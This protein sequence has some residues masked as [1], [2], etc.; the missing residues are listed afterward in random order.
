MQNV[1]KLSAESVAKSARQAN[2]SF[3]KQVKRRWRKR[4]REACEQ[5][6]DIVRRKIRS[7]LC[8]TFE[9][10]SASNRDLHAN[11]KLS[12]SRQWKQVLLI[13]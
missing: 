12:N 5:A 3:L 1:T 2:L 7:N 8:R 10:C 4:K 11:I 13:R 9:G 6:F